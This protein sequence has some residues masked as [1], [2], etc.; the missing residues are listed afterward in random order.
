[1][2]NA[3]VLIWKKE[4]PGAMGFLCIYLFVETTLSGHSMLLEIGWP[5]NSMGF[6]WWLFH[7]FGLEITLSGHVTNIIILLISDVH[8]NVCHSK[9]KA[10]KFTFVRVTLATN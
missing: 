6:F 3:F 8:Y 2:P 4:H 1:L 7:F 9:S 10:R 5:L